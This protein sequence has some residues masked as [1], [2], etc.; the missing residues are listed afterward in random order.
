MAIFGT[1]G[2][3]RRRRVLTEQLMTT[4]AEPARSNET[5][6]PASGSES[7]PA[8]YADETFASQ[9]TLISFIATRYATVAFWLLAASLGVVALQLGHVYLPDLEARIGSQPQLAAL[10][11]TARGN[12]GDWYSSL[13]LALATAGSLA[14]YSVRRHKTDDYSGRYRIWLW[15]AGAWL[16]LS[17]DT[18]AQF[19]LAIP[20]LARLLTGVTGWAGGA[21]WWFAPAVICYGA[22]GLRLALEVKPCRLAVVTLGMVY[23]CWLLALVA[24]L[25]GL[26]IESAHIAS[27]VQTSATMAGHVLLLTSLALYARFVVLDARGEITVPE[28]K[29][30]REKKPRRTKAKAPA[31]PE[32][33]ETELA[34]AESTD[35]EP[36]AKVTKPAKARRKKRVDPPHTAPSE[37]VAAYEEAETPTPASEPAAA[38]HVE[39][40]EAEHDETDWDDDPSQNRKLTK[41]QRRRLRKQAR[42]NQGLE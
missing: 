36:A 1:D 3:Q 24:S 13:L 2:G 7:R 34:E 16:L 28:P 6:V 23:G 25:G 9:P 10:D 32:S 4:A 30:K 27:V 22:L 35:A 12:L 18:T 39:Q 40:D 11:L 41:A 19:H 21:W 42:Q 20:P 17:A 5:S 8:R 15:A 31:E 38:A 26:A 37:P 33:T 29:P 14:I